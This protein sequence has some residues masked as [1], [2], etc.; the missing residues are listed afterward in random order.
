MRNHTIRYIAGE[1]I[2]V[3]TGEVIALREGCTYAIQGDDAA[4]TV[5]NRAYSV[6]AIRS[7]HA[8]AYAPW[9]EREDKEL[10]QLHAHGAT[11]KSLSEHFCRQT[12]AIQSRLRKLKR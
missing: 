10:L 8:N 2:D 4:F 9:T 1:L 5:D 3:E 12:G 7:T 6:A 11:I